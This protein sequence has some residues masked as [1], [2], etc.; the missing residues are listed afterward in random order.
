MLILGIVASSSRMSM[1]GSHPEGLLQIASAQSRALASCSPPTT[2]THT[3][4]NTA[5]HSQTSA[6]QPD[7]DRCSQGDY[8]ASKQTQAQTSYHSE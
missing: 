4:T 7:A 8:S 3:P 5:I 2:P 1:Q 6:Q